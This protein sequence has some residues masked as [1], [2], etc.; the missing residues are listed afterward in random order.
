MRIKQN[1]LSFLVLA[2]WVGLAV[3]PA[4]LNVAHAQN[5]SVTEGA[6]SIRALADR[7]RRLEQ[8]EFLNNINPEN[9]APRMIDSQSLQVGGESVQ[10]L[11]PLGM[12]AAPVVEQEFEPVNTVLSVYGP[13]GKLI[14]EVAASQGAIKQYQVGSAWAGYRITDIS[15]E[16]VTVVR[17]GKTRLIPVGGKL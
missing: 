13:E 1:R 11:P 7:Q 14:A 6:I 4:G 16:G 5:L 8:L 15:R 12:Q 10:I 2:G 3:L 9:T 17:S